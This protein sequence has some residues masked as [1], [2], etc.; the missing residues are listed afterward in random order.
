MS[1]PTLTEVGEMFFMATPP[2]WREASDESNGWALHH[3]CNALA[4]GFNHLHDIVV[5]DDEHPGWSAIL[6][7][8]RVND[9]ELAYPAMLRGVTLAPNLDAE[10]QRIRI[11]ETSNQN[12]GGP[13][14]I[15]GAARQF[16]TGERR[17]LLDEFYLDDPYQVRVRTFENETPYPDRVQAAL[18]TQV[19]GLIQ[20]TYEV[21]PGLTYG[22]LTGEE[23]DYAGLEAKGGTY[24]DLRRRQP[25]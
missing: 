3:L 1:E 17:V 23:V 15:K 2:R 16:L 22:E 12:R 13:D 21:V 5:G 7:P 20:L 8:D 25:L 18:E 9:D 24:G 11:A 6:D 19:P 14:A 4:I 10:S